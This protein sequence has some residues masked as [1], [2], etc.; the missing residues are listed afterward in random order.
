MPSQ[1]R[2]IVRRFFN[3]LWN[4]GNLAVADEIIAPHHIQHGTW[5]GNALG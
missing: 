3:D 2:Q 5:V 4:K 1:N